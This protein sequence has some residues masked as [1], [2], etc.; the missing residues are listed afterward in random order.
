MRPF[1][2]VVVLIS[3]IFQVT[4]QDL[5]FL[6]LNDKSSTTNEDYSLFKL[7]EHPKPEQMFNSKYP[8]LT[9]SSQFMIEHFKKYAKLANEIIT[10]RE[11]IGGIFV[12]SAPLIELSSPKK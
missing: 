1:L 5:N 6:M 2:L 11:L 7:L 8:F 10:V 4:A 9:G 12:L 3:F